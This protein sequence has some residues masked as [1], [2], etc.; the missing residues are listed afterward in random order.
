MTEAA[1]EQNE[2]IIDG[3]LA[4]EL[5]RKGVH[6]H[7]GDR[8]RFEVLDGGRHHELSSSPTPTGRPGLSWIGSIKNGPEDLAERSKE[9]L[10]AEL[11]QSGS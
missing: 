10:R 5:E 4:Q 7:P 3:P 1:H 8:V 6:L 9:I 11:G 2:L